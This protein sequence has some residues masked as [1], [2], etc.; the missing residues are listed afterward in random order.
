MELQLQA[1]S[2]TSLAPNFTKF[3]SFSRT[4]IPHSKSPLG[5][6]NPGRRNPI[7]VLA[8]NKKNKQDTHS[9][10][11]KPDE[12]TGPFPEAVLLKQVWPRTLSFFFLA[13][14]T[15]YW[16]C[17]ELFFFFPT[18]WVELFLLCLSWLI[19]NN[20]IWVLNFGMWVVLSFRRKFKK[21]EDFSLILLMRKNVSQ[22][23]CLFFFFF[24]PS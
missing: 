4:Q 16:I 2:A 22:L 5:F 17:V 19:S 6:F 13:F 18:I 23:F 10:V 3:A 20:R 11:P 1:S 12:A 9:F 7:I 21:M 15:G 14:S 8:K 24:F